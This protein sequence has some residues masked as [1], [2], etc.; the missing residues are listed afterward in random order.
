MS[1]IVVCVEEELTDIADIDYMHLYRDFTNDE[2]SWSLKEGERFLD[3]IH[4]SG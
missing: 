2:E 1:C 3:G 4:E